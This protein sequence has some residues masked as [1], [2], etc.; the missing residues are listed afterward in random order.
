M[1]LFFESDSNVGNMHE[2]VLKGNAQ[3]LGNMAIGSAEKMVKD[4]E[5]IFICQNCLK[6]DPMS[7]VCGTAR[8]EIERLKKEK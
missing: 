6:A 5:P 1:M 7:K 2:E 3:C 4:I 8:K